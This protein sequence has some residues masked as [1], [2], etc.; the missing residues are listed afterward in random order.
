MKGRKKRRQNVES[1][2]EVKRLIDLSALLQRDK[3]I[4]LQYASN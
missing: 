2:T 4:R 1:A 3:C